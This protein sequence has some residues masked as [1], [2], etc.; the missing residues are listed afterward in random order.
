MMEIY[1]Y[2]AGCMVCTAR[3]LHAGGDDEWFISAVITIFWPVFAPILLI[4]SVE[5]KLKI[6]KLMKQQKQR[7]CE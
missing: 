1:L 2:L 5:R 6:A 3:Y 4:A 7:S